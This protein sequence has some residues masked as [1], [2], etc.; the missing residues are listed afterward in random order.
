MIVALMVQDLTVNH[1]SSHVT[2]EFQSRSNNRDSARTLLLSSANTAT[3][4]LLACIIYC[5]CHS[6]RQMAILPRITTGW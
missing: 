2:A 4:T 6:E 1:E 3:C 5:S